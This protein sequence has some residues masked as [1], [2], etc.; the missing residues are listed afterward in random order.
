MQEE[1][2]ERGYFMIYRHN[3][4]PVNFKGFKHRG[5]LK[6]ARNRAFKHGDIM[7]YKNIWVI[8]QFSDLDEE[9]KGQQQSSSGEVK[10]L[11]NQGR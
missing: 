3:N 11:G 2:T 9:E 1:S 7:G 4:S 10:M 6:S 8:P 5:D